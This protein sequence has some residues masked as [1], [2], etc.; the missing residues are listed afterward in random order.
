[1]ADTL[2]VSLVI[3]IFWRV[4][5]LS[6]RSYRGWHLQHSCRLDWQTCLWPSQSPRGSVVG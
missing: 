2:G 6:M 4:V 3:F 1:M 5:Q